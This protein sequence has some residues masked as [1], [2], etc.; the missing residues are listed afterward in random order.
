MVQKQI[1]SIDLEIE[2]DSYLVHCLIYVNLFKKLP[3]IFFLMNN[4][5]RD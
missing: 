1:T 5:L 4:L 3:G 2:A